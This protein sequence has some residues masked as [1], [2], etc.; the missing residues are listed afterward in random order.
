MKNI[1]SKEAQLVVGGSGSVSDPAEIARIME[2]LR[3]QEEEA[4]RK[5]ANA[6][7]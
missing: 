5:A 1:N 3:R 2:E 4:R 6:A 7:N